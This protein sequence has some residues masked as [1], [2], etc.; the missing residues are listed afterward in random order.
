M[1]P[2]LLASSSPTRAK[3]LHDAGIEFI[4]KSVDFDEESIVAATPKEFVYLATLG[5][6]KKNLQHFGI[7]ENP[8]LVADTVVTCDNKIVRKAKTEEEARRMLLE[9]SGNT[10]SIITCMIFHS[11]ELQLTDISATHYT[12]R[13]FSH[14]EL[15]KYLESGEWQGKAGGCMVEGFCKQYIASTKGQ[16]STAMGLHVELLQRFLTV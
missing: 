1:P 15:E 4:Q 5:K 2:I 9:Q 7:Q 3:I 14:N 10:T 8:L 6:Y 12:F 16:Q 13:E 11:K